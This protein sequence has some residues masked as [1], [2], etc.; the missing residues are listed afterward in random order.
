[1]VKKENEDFRKVFIVGQGP[2]GISSAENLR[3]VGYTG[4]IFVISEEN[5]F[6]I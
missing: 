2:G 6:P 5:S 3:K 4:D 1:M